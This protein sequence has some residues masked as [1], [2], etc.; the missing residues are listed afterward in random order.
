MTVETQQLPV[1][2]VGRIVVVIVVPVMNRQTV[3]LSAVAEVAAAP[4][5]DPWVNLEGMRPHVFSSLAL[6]V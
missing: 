6:A 1:A 5:A 2:A 3:K 4:C